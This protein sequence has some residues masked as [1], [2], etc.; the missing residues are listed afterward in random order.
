MRKT[1][2][3]RLTAQY[4]RGTAWARNG[5]GMV[6]ELALS[7][8]TEYQ[9]INQGSISTTARCPDRIQK[10]VLPGIKRPEREADRAHPC[11]S[12]EYLELYL[13]ALFILPMLCLSQ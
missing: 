5:N 13:H 4:G 10:D 7:V 12:K 6:C 11:H 8:V 3:K 1:Q 9:L 2:S